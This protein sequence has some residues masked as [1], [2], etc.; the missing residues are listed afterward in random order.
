M[1]PLWHWESKYELLRWWRSTEDSP[2]PPHPSLPDVFQT[3]GR[4]AFE[5]RMQR[6]R[7]YLLLKNSS[8]DTL[9]VIFANFTALKVSKIGREI[10]L[11]ASSQHLLQGRNGLIDLTEVGGGFSVSEGGKWH[12]AKASFSTWNSCAALWCDTGGKWHE[13]EWSFSH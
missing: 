10:L 13:R 7:A 8:R 12:F 4:V 3:A 2:P 6:S 11:F 5:C 1:L 9:R